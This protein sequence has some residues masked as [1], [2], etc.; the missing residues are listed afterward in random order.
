VTIVLELFTGF[1][2]V[3][4]LTPM[5][6]GSNTINASRGVAKPT[7]N[8]VLMSDMIELLMMCGSNR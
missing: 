8:S 3:G 7:E 6:A 1:A 5:I 2:A 4:L